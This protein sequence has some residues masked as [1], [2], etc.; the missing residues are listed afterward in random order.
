MITAFFVPGCALLLRARAIPDGR[1]RLLACAALVVPPTVITAIAV[2]AY[3]GS[4]V[5]TAGYTGGFTFAEPAVLTQDWTS[6]NVALATVV[7]FALLAVW[8]GTAIALPRRFSAVVLAGLGA[9][10]LVAVLQLTSHVSQ[11][12]EPAAAADTTG[13]I[14]STGL[15]PGE[16]LAVG[17]G[18]N[19]SYW[20]PQAYVVWWAPIEFFHAATQPPPANASVVELYWPSGQP[21]QASWP[22]APAGWQIV[23]TNGTDGWVAWRHSA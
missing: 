13:M 18:L 4:S 1:R 3:A 9:V 2:F 22:T 5:S 12:S 6:A 16:H 21:A 7:A 23:A 8:V 10:S 19:W 17:Y 20:M 11:A 14:A 15:K